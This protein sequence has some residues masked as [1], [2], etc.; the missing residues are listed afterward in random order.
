MYFHK[1]IVAHVLGKGNS[2]MAIAGWIM[3]EIF[4]DE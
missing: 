2:F 1:S 3:V 4:M